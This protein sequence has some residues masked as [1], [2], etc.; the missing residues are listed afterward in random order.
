MTGVSKMP[1]DIVTVNQ[2]ARGK[3]VSLLPKISGTY[4]SWGQCLT[5]QKLTSYV[6]VFEIPKWIPMVQIDKSCAN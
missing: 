4:S 1:I 3:F 5:Q 2:I 6:I